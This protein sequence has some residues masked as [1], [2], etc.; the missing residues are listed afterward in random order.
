M[1]PLLDCGNFTIVNSYILFRSRLEICKRCVRRC[2]VMV[3]VMVVVVA[4]I[5]MVMVVVVALIVMVMVVV[6]ALMVMVVALMVMV[7]AM[8]V[9]LLVVMTL[10]LYH[11]A[12][13]T[14]YPRTSHHTHHP[15]FMRICTHPRAIAPPTRRFFT[16]WT[17]R[18]HGAGVDRVGQCA[19]GRGWVW[20]TDG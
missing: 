17:Q 4:L 2:V 20:R 19:G 8:V 16:R 14:P 15:I 11:I 1:T 18:E 9:A 10:C 3:L 5:V 6:V 7:T 13:T 12:P